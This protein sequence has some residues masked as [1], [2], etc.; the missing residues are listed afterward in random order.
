[1]KGSSWWTWRISGWKNLKNPNPSLKKLPK[2]Q[3][4]RHRKP[5]RPLMKMLKRG[6][7]P[8]T[9]S[10]RRSLKRTVPRNLNHQMR[11]ALAPP[12]VLVS[13]RIEERLRNDQTV[14]ALQKRPPPKQVD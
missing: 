9:S 6:R 14:T 4:N 10:C 3:T 12:E 8:L 13:S 5:I 11:K 1:R 2:Q 7:P